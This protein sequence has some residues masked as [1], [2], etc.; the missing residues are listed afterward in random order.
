[1]VSWKVAGKRQ[2][3]ATASGA[4]LLVFRHRHNHAPVV[5][6]QL[7]V[8]IGLWIARKVNYLQI[9]ILPAAGF[10]RRAMTISALQVHQVAFVI[11][12]VQMCSMAEGNGCR[13]VEFT[14]FGTEL[15]MMMFVKTGDLG[16]ERPAM[17]VMVWVLFL[18]LGGI[19]VLTGLKLRLAVASCALRIR[20]L[21]LANKPPMLNVA[22]TTGWNAVF[23]LILL[24]IGDILPMTAKAGTV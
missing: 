19:C 24:V 5:W 16:P 1:M 13:I 10:G 3:M 11:F 20:R 21:Y 6:K 7:L 17:P 22:R 15:G 2:I 9:R 4:T 8:G 23:D 12:K 18:L 14:S